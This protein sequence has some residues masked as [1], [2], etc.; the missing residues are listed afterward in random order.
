MLRLT[1]G[2]TIKFE[3]IPLP[4]GGRMLTYADQTELVRAVEQLEAVVNIDHLT[5]IFNRRYLYARG[6]QETALA[7]R[8]RRPLSLLMLD[9]DHFKQVND[10]HGHAA[11]DVVLHAVAQCCQT[12]KRATDLAGR[13]G[14]EE[15]AVVLPETPLPQALQAAERLRR[16]VAA[17]GVQ[18]GDRNL[19][20]TASFGVAC[21]QESDA[22]FSSLLRRADAALYVAKHDGR[23]RVAAAD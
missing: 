11:G 3:C 17:N 6:E 18:L 16:A 5:Q 4:Q 19:T 22:D 13:L 23:N 8:H 1:D 15:F 2:R 12:T 21:L 14:G 10:V 7:R 20:V 9:I